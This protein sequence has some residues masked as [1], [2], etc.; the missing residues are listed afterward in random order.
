MTEFSGCVMVNIKEN[1][2][3]IIPAY[4]PPKEFVDYARTVA[5]LAKALIVVNDGSGAEY[6]P[7][8]NE[9]AAI[10]GVT[11]LTYNGNQGKGFALKHAF[12]H[13]IETYSPETII[14][15]ADCDGQHKVKDI[16]NVYKAAFSHPDSLNLGSRNFNQAN[17]PKRSRA[18]NTSMRRMFKIFYGLSVYDTQTGLRG[19]SVELSKRFVEVSG[20]RFEFELGQLIYCA[21]HRITINETPIDTVY[22]DDPGEHI[23][24]FRTIRDSARVTGVMLTNFGYFLISSVLSAVVDVGAFWLLSVLL[25]IVIDIPWLSLIIATIG[26]RV[27]SSIINFI[28]NY[29]YVFSGVGKSALIR[30]YILW[31]CQ[32][33]ASYGI[34]SFLTQIVG[35]PEGFILALLKGFGDM[36]LGLLSYQI[37]QHWVFRGHDRKK[38]WG[39]LVANA[40]TIVR[41]FS[42]KYR[43][44][45]ISYED[46]AVYV[47]RHLN[48]HGPYTTLKW[49]SFHVHPMML[50]VFF[51]KKECYRQYADYTFTVREGK[52]SGKFNLKAYLASRIVVPAVHSARSIPVYR[53]GTMSTFKTMKLT[54]DVLKRNENVIIYPDIDYVGDG[55]ESEIYDGFL[56]LGEI[57]RRETGKSLKFVPLYIDDA[58]RTIT[59]YDPVYVDKYKESGAKAKEYLQCAINGR[60]YDSSYLPETMLI[61]MDVLDTTTDEVEKEEHQGEDK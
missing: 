15:T 11:Y 28:I 58:A 34:A 50:S 55:G 14:V 21:R 44:N 4:E 10:D 57:Y 36:C 49:L 24:H 16:V 18:G 40:Q 19:F 45:V 48:M 2:V 35:L 20:N 60:P 32:L 53:G 13:C 27:I 25:P 17:V 43:A 29:K 6:D 8:F 41:P 59:A 30:Y 23:S 39:P 12:S 56:Y 26:A 3:V 22:P 37:Q 9:I 33:G 54:V 47:C 42:K 61:G 51:T 5:R 46:G 38:F 52:A 31:T 7:I 1:L